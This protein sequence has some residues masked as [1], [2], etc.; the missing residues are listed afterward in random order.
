MIEY[1]N[2]LIEEWSN[3]EEVEMWHEMAR[4]TLGIAGRAF[5]GVDL[6]ED[7][8]EIARGMDELFRVVRRRIGRSVPVAALDSDASRATCE[9][10]CGHI[11]SR[12]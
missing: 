9:T 7:S 8:P 11:A 10:K 3:G 12:R 4:L 1:S 2:R 5:F 6:W